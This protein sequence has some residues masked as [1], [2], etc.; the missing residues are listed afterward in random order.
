[1][2]AKYLKAYVGNGTKLH[3]GYE[4]ELNEGRKM[5]RVR[6]GS[7]RVGTGIFTS[8]ALDLATY[9]E[10]KNACEKCLEREA[11]RVEA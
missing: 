1:M 2:K 11:E 3:I 6:C 9:S 5:L 10:N 7:R 4:Y 8:G